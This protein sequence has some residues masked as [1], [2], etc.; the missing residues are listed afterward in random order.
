MKKTLSFLT[1]SL[2]V[3]ALFIAQAHA[4]TIDDAVSVGKGAAAGIAATATAMLSWDTASIGFAKLNTSLRANNWKDRSLGTACALGKIATSA[5]LAYSASRFGTYA[6]KSIKRSAHNDLLDI[7]TSAK[8][9]QS[10]AVSVVKGLSALL[11]AGGAAY[12]NKVAAHKLYND[13]KNDTQLRLINKAELILLRA[14]QIAGCTY[15]VVKAL[16]YAYC[17]LTKAVGLDS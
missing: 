8:A 6:R 10:R 15:T 7:K 16:P 11:V 1:L 14:G 17:N 3:P 12:L 2:L 5:G 9:S 13:I 4:V